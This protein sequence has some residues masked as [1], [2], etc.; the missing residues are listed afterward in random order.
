V[1]EENMNKE[2]CSG[3]F[4]KKVERRNIVIK[5]YTEG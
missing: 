1:L 4:L 3:H 2:E 5:Y